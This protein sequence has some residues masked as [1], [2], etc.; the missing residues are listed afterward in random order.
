MLISPVSEHLSGAMGNPNVM[1]TASLASS[2]IQSQ[3]QSFLHYVYQHTGIEVTRVDVLPASPHKGYIITSADGNY[4]VLKTSPSSNTRL[5]RCE[6]SSPAGEASIL[7]RLS[8]PM[9]LNFPVP[10]LLS[11]SNSS[12]SPLSGPYLLRSYVA[13]IPLSSISHRLTTYDREQIDKTVG[14]HLRHAVNNTSSQFGTIARIDKGDGYGSWREAFHA[15]FEAVLRDAEDAVLTLP[16]QSIRHYV[17]LHMHHL[18]AVTEPRLVPL[19]AGTP[20]TVLLDENR[21]CVVGILSWGDVL[22][23]D[24][25]LGEVFTGA[26][27]SFWLGFGGQQILQYGDGYDERRSQIYTVYRSIVSIVRQNFRPRLGADESE[28][29]RIL[30]WALNQL[31]V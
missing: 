3:I 11:A 31:A 30:N 17:G 14:A 16:Y 9:L 20:E 7:Q 5:L 27:S 19:R 21:K 2:K 15:L 22:W 28:H 24:P 6:A 8:G 29:R 12:S 13:G 23:G 4:F 26:T 10:R 18:D 1:M 25:S